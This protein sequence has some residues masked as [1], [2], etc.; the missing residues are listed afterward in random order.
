MTSYGPDHGVDS[1]EVRDILG[2]LKRRKSPR[3]YWVDI[4]GFGACRVLVFCREHLELFGEQEQEYHR[5]V[6]YIG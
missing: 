3:W 1:L 2:M 4:S 6:V 5:G